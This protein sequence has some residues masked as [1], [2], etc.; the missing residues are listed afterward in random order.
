[1]LERAHRRS[2]RHAASDALVGIPKRSTLVGVV[3]AG[4][5]WVLGAAAVAIFSPCP[6]R[7]GPLA[8]VPGRVAFENGA[9]NAPHVEVTSPLGKTPP[10][11][12][13]MVETATRGAPGAELG[14]R[15]SGGELGAKQRPDTERA[16]V[17][18]R[19]EDK[20]Y[21]RPVGAA[22]R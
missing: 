15:A 19:V 12:L 13:P 22:R 8:H 1:M 9:A 2:T 16:V 18:V 10:R 11:A 3:T 5:L 20:R 14:V 17:T 7:A 21:L 4:L 6:P